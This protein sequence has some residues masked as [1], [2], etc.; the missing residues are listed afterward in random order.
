M[1]TSWLPY[2]LAA[3][4]ALTCTAAENDALVEVRDGKTVT[5]G[6]LL[7][8]DKERA[9]LLDRTGRLHDLALGS[10]KLEETNR[11]FQSLSVMDLRNQLSHEFGKDL[12]IGSTR[13][14]LVLA[15]AGRASEYAKVFEEQYTTLQ[16]YFKLRGFTLSDPQ[17]PLV[18]VVFPS[19][20]QFTEYA[21]EEGSKTMVNMQG[22]YSPRSNRVALFESN[23]KSVAVSMI[24]PLTPADRQMPLFGTNGSEV[25]ATMI[26]EA[27]HQI[28]YNIGLHSRTGET[29]RWVVEG[30]ATAF[31]PDG[32]RSSL[33]SSQPYQRINRERYLVFQN[34]VKSG[35]RPAKS[36]R[37]FVESDAL[38]E[39]SVLD[40][41]A[42]SWALTFFLVETRPRNYS[43]YLK[44]IAARDPF[45]SY[46]PKERLADFK[47]TIS[48]D[49]DSLDTQ[50]VKFIDG[51]K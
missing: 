13:H 31:E 15:S 9:I 50:F 46:S 20:K 8:K 43:A 16:R 39:T 26:H 10:V 28:A 29:P 1:R 44:R 12:E 18:A 41:Y 17:F 2:V 11:N 6:K 40:F 23:E 32:M 48:A 35:R 42:Q 45:A 4:S 36:L 47:E 49:V 37:S 22:Y 19:Q 33:A 3:L 34:F 51:L 7:A 24:D 27:T 38:Y 21:R 14:Y 30:M 5:T 25:K